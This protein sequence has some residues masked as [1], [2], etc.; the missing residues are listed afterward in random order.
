[1]PNSFIPGPSPTIP[2]NL[3]V[4]IQTPWQMA[5]HSGIEEQIP[6][7]KAPQGNSWKRPFTAILSKVFRFFKP[8]PTPKPESQPKQPPPRIFHPQTT[9]T[10]NNVT[11][12]LLT[13][14]SVEKESVLSSPIKVKSD[15]QRN[16]L[17]AT[18][19][20]VTAI[21]TLLSLLS[22][23]PGHIGVSVF[24]QYITAALDF[25][26]SMDIYVILL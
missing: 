16:Y 5:E 14:A 9:S 11:Q 13:A 3:R 25:T 26:V 15:F 21:I 24:A 22:V 2:A 10:A 8:D 6:Q 4:E 23:L 19:L 7:T 17:V 1:M 20:A 18:G 12:T